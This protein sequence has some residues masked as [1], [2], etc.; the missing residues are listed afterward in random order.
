MVG[1]AEFDG[2]PGIINTF[3][4]QSAPAGRPRSDSH[5]LVKPLDLAG[6]DLDPPLPLGTALEVV[7]GNRAAAKDERTVIRLGEPIVKARPRNAQSLG[8][9]GGG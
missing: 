4:R 3:G 7:D 1:N 9:V 6:L 8:R 5:Q 2:D